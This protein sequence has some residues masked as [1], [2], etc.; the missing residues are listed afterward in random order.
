MLAASCF[1]PRDTP[2]KKIADECLHE[3]IEYDGS[4]YIDYRLLPYFG[5]LY[6]VLCF[7]P[8]ILHD[9]AKSAKF[10]ALL[11]A[12]AIVSQSVSAQEYGS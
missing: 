8:C 6:S 10:E 12:E 9:K 4:N 2:V 1:C 11:T 3:Y 5:Q 7:S